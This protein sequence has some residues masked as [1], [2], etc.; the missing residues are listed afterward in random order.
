MAYLVFKI[1]ENNQ[2]Y[3]PMTAYKDEHGGWQIVDNQTITYY[4][5]SAMEE[6]AEAPKAE[7]GQSDLIKALAVAL[8]SEAAVQA[9][10]G[11]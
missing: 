4:A 8:H 10:K 6:S 5:G 1:V 11:E 3:D 7:G 9:I 2:G